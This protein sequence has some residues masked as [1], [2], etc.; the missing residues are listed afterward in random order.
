MPAPEFT[1]DGIIIQTFQEVFDE[2]EESLRLIYGYDL[3]LDQDTPDGQRIA[4]FAKIILDMQSFAVQLRNS[5]DPDLAEGV[6]L[7]SII[8]LAG[9]S[10]NPATRS[11]W[12]LEVTTDRP[13]TLDIDYKVRD[14]LGQI[15]EI[16][17]LSPVDLPL[18]TTTVTFQAENFG[19]VTG[20]VGFAIT[21]VTVVIGVVSIISTVL[22]GASSVGLDEETDEELRVRRNKSVR[23]P[24][25]STVGSLFARVGD[26]LGVSDLVVYENKESVFDPILSLNPHSIWLV[27][28]G[29]VNSEITEILV[30]NKTAGTGLKGSVIETFTEDLLRP[31]G[32]I[33]KL[34]HEVRFDRPVITDLDVQVDLTKK[35]PLDIIDE[36][37]I[38]ERISETKHIIGEFLESASLYEPAFTAGDNFLLSNMAIRVTGSGNPFVETGLD[39]GAD[40]KFKIEVANIAI[41][42]LP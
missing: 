18:G 38:K 16:A 34:V 3:A 33:F 28:D 32:S 19:Q 1:N 37:L 41:T 39:A 9:I 10:R 25:F 40:V 20:E 29:G 12:N 30:K 7:D 13:L 5:Y 22:L 17:S 21:Q 26:L 27:V 4:I 24:A 11:Q 35:Q 8:K 15:W 23:N 42:V 36:A 6:S 31:D 2:I 14:E